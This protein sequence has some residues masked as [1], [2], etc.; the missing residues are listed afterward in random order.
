MK[1]DNVQ[2]IK[3]VNHP[4]YEALI[5]WLKTAR[6]EQGLSVRELGVQIDESHQFVNKIELCQRKLNVFEFVQYCDALGL[7]P[8]EGIE[9]LCN[10]KKQG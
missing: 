4:R 6:L 9:L 5:A 8:K 2:M 7:D 1:P 3:Y 10:V